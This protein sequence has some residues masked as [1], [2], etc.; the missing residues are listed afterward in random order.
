MR[1]TTEGYFSKSIRRRKCNFQKL[2]KLAF[3]IKR[4]PISRIFF[5]C[6]TDMAR[7]MDTDRDMDGDTERQIHGQGQR[8]GHR[9][10]N[11][12]GHGTGTRPGTRTR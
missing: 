10:E 4:L 3:F 8:Q 1:R 6:D 9:Q 12:H 7:T 5:I 11:G 2:K